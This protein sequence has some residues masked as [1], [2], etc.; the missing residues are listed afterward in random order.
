MSKKRAV[1]VVF[2]TNPDF[3]YQYDDE[4]EAETLPPSQQRL[5]ARIEKN[6]RG[7]KTVTVV[8][9]FVGADEDLQELARLLKNKC[10]VGGS[11][12][13]GEILVQGEHLEKVKQILIG[14]GY[15]C[16]G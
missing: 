3:E 1:G 14:A 11:A 10:G 9:G 16:K 2:S 4:P 8:S 13:E 12:K 7:G 5:R 6:H 15:Q